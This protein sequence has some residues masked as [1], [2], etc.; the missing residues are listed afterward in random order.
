MFETK[1]CNMLLKM[2]PQKNWNTL[3]KCIALFSRRTIGSPVE[4]TY[5]NFVLKEYRM[6]TMDEGFKETFLKFC[7]PA[8]LHNREEEIECDK[9]YWGADSTFVIFDT[10]KHNEIVG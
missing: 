9:I 10:N 5:K 4:L 1:W 6:H 2:V 8:D 3:S 7:Y